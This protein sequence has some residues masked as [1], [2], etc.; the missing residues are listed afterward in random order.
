MAA[1]EAFL[2]RVHDGHQ[3]N[4]GQIQ[5][6]PEEVDPDQHVKFAQTQIAQDLH[7]LHSIYLG[8]NKAYPYTQ[9]AQVFGQLLSHALSQGGHQYPLLLR[10][11]LPR[12][13]Q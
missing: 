10:N 1:E 8:V 4:L 3:R 13:V 12:L 2:V 5:P 11:P 6:L 7:A 9:I